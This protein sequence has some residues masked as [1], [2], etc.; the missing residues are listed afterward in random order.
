LRAKWEVMSPSD[1][2]VPFR[3]C[4]SCR[5]KIDVLATLPRIADKPA[6]RVYRCLPCGRVASVEI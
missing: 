1:S 3:L 4:E 5:R 6:L 2:A